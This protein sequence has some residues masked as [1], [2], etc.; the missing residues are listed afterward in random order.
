MSKFYK[1]SGNVLL[2]AMT[3][4]VKDT[5]EKLSERYGNPR[6]FNELIKNWDSFSAEN[7]ELLKQHIS[8]PGV[9]LGDSRSVL[10]NL[11]A[12]LSCTDSEI[13]IQ[14]FNGFIDKN[15]SLFQRIVVNIPSSDLAAI[16]SM[17]NLNLNTPTN[18]I[19]PERAAAIRKISRIIRIIFNMNLTGMF[20]TQGGISGTVRHIDVAINIVLI[21]QIWLKFL[22]EN[23]QLIDPYFSEFGA[24][25]SQGHLD[26]IDDDFIKPFN[27]LLMAVC[28]AMYNTERNER[29]ASY[30]DEILGMQVYIMQELG[31]KFINDNFTQL[32]S[33]LRNIYVLLGN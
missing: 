11:A 6:L 33:L 32:N 21:K 17:L 22:E 18:T 26:Y 25:V 7:I 29:L 24:E 20:S 27:Q 23:K 4:L 3:F 28:S 10:S 12:Y 14:V 16:D 1:D 2:L 5:T 13:L 9:F 19:S 8:D 30:G 15:R 31:E